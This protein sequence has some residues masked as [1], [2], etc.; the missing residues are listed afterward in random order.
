MISKKDSSDF[1][2]V[3]NDKIN[4]ALYL[5][6]EAAMDAIEGGEEK[7]KE[8]AASMLQGVGKKVDRYPLQFLVGVAASSFILGYIFGKNEPENE[9]LSS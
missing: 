6:A 2:D 9:N 4:E 1:S 8:K 5:F 3:P 7:L